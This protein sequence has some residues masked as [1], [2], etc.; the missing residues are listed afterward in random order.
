MRETACNATAIAIDALACAQLSAHGDPDCRALGSFDSPGLSSEASA[1]IAE[2]VAGSQETQMGSSRPHALDLTPAAP[3]KARPC[4]SFRRRCHSLLL[5]LTRGD[6]LF[7]SVLETSAAQAFSPLMPRSPGL[8]SS[9]TSLPRSAD[10]PG[11]LFPR[12]PVSRHDAAH[13][14][15]H[16][17]APIKLSV[18]FNRR[19]RQCG[20]GGMWPPHIPRLRSAVTW[21]PSPVPGFLP[22]I[23]NGGRPSSGSSRVGPSQRR[24]CPCRC[25]F[26]RRPKPA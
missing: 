7:R 9:S 19:R 21:P 13:I 11:L 16:P 10:P 6:L 15:D 4:S 20:H 14:D 25:R 22:K 2:F 18:V 3:T 1:Q 8:H 17:N 5:P 23:P 24:P 26:A 12:V